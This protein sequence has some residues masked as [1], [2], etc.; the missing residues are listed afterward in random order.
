MSI[1]KS[2]K[3]E[4]EGWGS[5]ELE[6][7]KSTRSFFQP[8]NIEEIPFQIKGFGKN[9]LESDP[10]Y[11]Y[12]W[13]KIQY[14]Y[15]IED[16]TAFTPPFKL[17]INN[18]TINESKVR[19]NNHLLTGQFSYDDEVGETKI[20]IRDN[21]NKQIFDLTT[22]VFPQ[23]MDY[24]SDYKAM[25][26]DISEIIQNLAY[27]SLKQTF[28]RSRAR[29]S[30]QATQNEWWNILD[31]L[32][33]ELLINLEVIKRQPKHEIRSREKVLPIEKIKSSSKKNIEWLL[34][35]TKYSNESNKGI[36]VTT[37]KFYTHALSSKKYIT[38]DT[39]E[40]RFIAWAVIDIIE[41]LRQYKSWYV[42]VS[43]F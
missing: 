3:F 13:Q 6:I 16:S 18:R 22:E 35:N 25:M 43:C 2:Y 12:E 8:R 4:N 34:K 27:D 28:K 37:S 33:E 21:G 40:N 31:A 42:K 39:Y 11:F 29:I 30:G 24:K 32:F 26:A 38:Y 1:P 15:L 17:I 19:G 10:F 7:S 5:L 23:K 14:S 36:K 9:S 41:K 20:E